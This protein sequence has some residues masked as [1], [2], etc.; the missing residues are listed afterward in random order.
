MLGRIETS[1]R[2]SE[3]ISVRLF[4]LVT[5]T[6]IFLKIKIVVNGGDYKIGLFQSLHLQNVNV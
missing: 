5:V 4:F 3:L 2:L 1:N 6:G